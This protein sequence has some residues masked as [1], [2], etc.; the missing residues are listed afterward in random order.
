MPGPLRDA[1]GAL[2][3]L[4]LTS[5][6][7]M[8]EGTGTTINDRIGAF[9]GAS[10]V[11]SPWLASPW[12]TG[13]TVFDTPTNTPSSG[14]VWG[15]S[16]APSRPS[17]TAFT[18]CGWVNYDTLANLPI[19]VGWTSSGGAA[20]YL[21][22]ANTTTSLRC[23]GRGGIASTWTVPTLTTGKWTFLA[24]TRNA[25]NAMR[26]YVDGVESS[27]GAQTNADE[28]GFD[29]IGRYFT[30]AAGVYGP[31]NPDGKLAGW[32]YGAVELTAAQIQAAMTAMQRSGV[33]Y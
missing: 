16:P 12:L 14:V 27:T 10:L 7:P 9:P 32:A 30:G 5:F 28:F 15:S 31:N 3:A 6:W 24:V 8:D 11:A 22:Y 20:E 23:Q 1:A 25:A 33:S 4:G 18:I 2:K 26:I 21:L 13:T 19:L 17:G 29:L